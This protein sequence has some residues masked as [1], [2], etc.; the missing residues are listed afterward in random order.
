MSVIVGAASATVF[1]DVL[2]NCDI[3]SLLKMR[4]VVSSLLE[5]A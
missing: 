2:S 5:K 4:S 1:P 3:A